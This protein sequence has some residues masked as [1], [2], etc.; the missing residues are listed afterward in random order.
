M[1]GRDSWVKRIIRGALSIAL[2]F[3]VCGSGRA[4]TF[5][6]DIDV[7]S[8]CASVEARLIGHQYADLD[9]L[10]R[11]MRD[12]NV[13]LL[14]GNSQLYQFY[15][16]LAAFDTSVVYSCV[17]RTPFDQKRALLEQWVKT[18]PKSIAAR[19]A[20]SDFWVNTGWHFRGPGY[21]DTV[22]DDQMEHFQTA[23]L[24]A[25]RVLATVDGRDDPHI[26]YML[27]E[28]AE[29]EAAPRESARSLLDAL[30]A[31][32]VS[33]YPSYYHYYSRR[34][35]DLQERWYGRPGEVKGYAQSLLKTPGGDAGLV[36]YSYVANNL[37]QLNQRSSL[38]EAT[39]L[40][41]PTI[42]QAYAT[43]ERLYGL[44]NRDW[45]ALCNLA[46]AGADRE[47]ARSALTHIGDNWD[48]AVW[49]ERRYFDE[50]VAW[51]DQAA[52]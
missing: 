47:A 16:A 30:Y 45:N 7:A 12:P 17:S 31:S 18:S 40:S 20:L 21:V 13:R 46:L 50:A 41:W 44:R 4:A 35:N 3:V 34:A 11:E 25:K 23:V 1:I 38:L 42:K 14:G 37:M 2:A 49:K 19:I 26:Y 43:R 51:I 10:E 22:S 15:G 48:P 8:L 27:M 28:I 32:A 36:A 6:R 5:S 39:G 33:A 24:N 52:R 29:G 9:Q